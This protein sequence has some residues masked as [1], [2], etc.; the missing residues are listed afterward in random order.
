MK[1]K[2]LLIGLLISSFAIAQ[3]SIAVNTSKKYISSNTYTE[4]PVEI[5]S[6]GFN[7]E[8]IDAGANTKYSEFAS[9]FFKGKLI[10]VSSKKIGG[11]AKLDPNTKEGYKNLFCL[12]VDEKG[13]LSAPLLFSRILNTNGS[14]GQLTFSPDQTVVYYTRSA[15]S[16][17]LKYNL[18]KATLKENSHGSWIQNELVN[19]NTPNAS[20]ET[21]YLSKDGT[22]LYFASDM[23]GS[24]G[25][26]DIFVADINEDGTL[27]KPKNLGHGVNSTSDEK[28]PSLSVDGKALYFSSK[29]HQNLGGYDVF[30]SKIKD[31]DTYKAPRNLGNTLNTSYDEVAFFFTT[32]NEGYISSNKP[33]GKGGYDIYRAINSEVTQSIKGSIRDLTTKIKLPNTQVVLIDED[34][35]EVA[36]MKTDENGMFTFNKIIPFEEYTIKTQKDGFE[37][38]NFEFIADKGYE[39]EYNKSF[40]LKTKAAVIE[41][42]NDKLQIVLENIYFDYAKYSIKEESTISLNKVIKVLNENPNMKLA[43]NAHTDIRG[44]DSY[45]FRL[46]NKRAES[47]LKYIIKSGIDKNRIVSEGF[48]ETQPLVDCKSKTCSDKDH[49]TNRRIEFVILD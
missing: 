47:A 14:E 12:D 25:G 22:K 37:D 11:L 3:T 24:I 6:N 43:I 26:F 27:S 17:S 40:D 44:N 2:L 18:Y 20:I 16:N 28:Y 33:Q 4:T 7:F 46:S 45:N 10:S 34:N 41:K 15:K 42:V 39:T 8:V 38:G 49:E 32:K 13:Q 5:K 30:M 19:I 23:E 9:G 31:N 36:K 29:G 35:N 48:G 1:A 21:P